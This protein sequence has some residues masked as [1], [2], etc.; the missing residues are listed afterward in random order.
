MRP[1]DTR[2]PGAL[3]HCPATRRFVMKAPAFT[4]NSRI[5]GQGGHCHT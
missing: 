4:D 3:K 2:H 1:A 5:Y